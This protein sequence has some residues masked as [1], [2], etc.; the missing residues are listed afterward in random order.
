MNNNF[1]PE[2]HEEQQ[3]SVS[4]LMQTLRSITAM[5]MHITSV[6]PIASQANN[7]H[8][9]DQ[10]SNPNKWSEYIVSLM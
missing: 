3:N 6:L 8:M 2:K 1:P 7:F 4:Q 9:N 10:T 5:H